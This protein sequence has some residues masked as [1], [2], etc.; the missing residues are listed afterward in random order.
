MAMGY[1]AAKYVYDKVTDKGDPPDTSGMNQAAVQ[2]AQ[3]SK[4]QLDWA[5]QIYAESAPDRAE[6]SA[7]GREMSDLQLEQTRKQIAITDDYNEYNQS[8]FR[9]LE[10]SIVA[11]AQNYDT[12]ERRNAARTDAVAD[13]E[14]NL[15]VSRGITNRTLERRGVNP[16]SGAY[17]TTQGAMELGGA[18][19]KAGAANTAV[20]NVELQGYA[21]KMDAAGLGRNLAT[22]QATSAGIALN[23]GNSAVTNGQVPLNVAGQG[24]ALLNAGYA[25]AQQGLFGAGQT[26]GK[27]AEI[28]MKANDNS[29]MLGALGSVAGAYVAKSDVNAKNDIQPVNPD[30]ALEAV[31]KTPVSNWAYKNGAVPGDTGEKHTGPMAQ[32]VQKNMGEKAGPG[33]KKIDLV[34]MN[35]ITMAA[36]QGLSKKV[37]KIMAAQGLPM[38]A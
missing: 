24:A 34:T 38:P 4:E 11:D 19:A 6:A 33:G 5:K 14:A 9:P 21:R 10:K 31:E 28:D 16:A 37:D 35:G 23:S 2:Q 27:L 32:D 3:I 12:A 30:E 36:I 17:A 15:A 25:G 13:V 18:A 8:T 26:F 20:K 22:N 1:V 29:A 7:R